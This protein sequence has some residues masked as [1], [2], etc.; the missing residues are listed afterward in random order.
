MSSG[1]LN[2][3]DFRKKKE[4]LRDFIYVNDAIKM[5]RFL[6]IKKK[7]GLYNIG[8]GK[9]CTFI[10]VAEALIKKLGYGKI[11][12]IKFPSGLKNKYQHYTKANISKLLKLGYKLLMP[13]LRSQQ[14]WD[15]HNPHL[16]KL[17]LL[18]TRLM[19]YQL[20]LWLKKVLQIV[21][22]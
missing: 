12:Y 18:L 14:A 4:P 1:Y 19:L 22:S 5:M 16:L 21:F 7:S 17:P 10:N 13:F 3:F 6:M 20:C 11:N 8:T 9:P 15:Y 2:L